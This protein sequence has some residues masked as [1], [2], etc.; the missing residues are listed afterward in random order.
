[1][2]IAK[3]CDRAD[4]E[5]VDGSGEGGGAVLGHTIPLCVCVCVCIIL[6]RRRSSRS[7]RNPIYKCYIYST[8]CTYTYIYDRK[9]EIK[10]GG[11]RG[12]GEWEGYEL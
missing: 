3:G 8:Y 1:M 12:K 7:Y 9:R 6:G 5:V 2:Y 11:G 4:A 10:G